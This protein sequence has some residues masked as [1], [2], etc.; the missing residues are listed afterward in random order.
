[1]HICIC[2]FTGGICFC[3]VLI[4]V[5]YFIWRLIKPFVYGLLGKNVE[6]EQL[7]A[8]GSKK[9]IETEKEGDGCC[10]P[11]DDGSKKDD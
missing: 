7:N 9:S 11:K 4:P 3:G 2:S 5:F 1:M 6:A 8:D 10:G